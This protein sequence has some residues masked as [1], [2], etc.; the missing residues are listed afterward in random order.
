MPDAVPV[1]KEI[2]LSSADDKTTHAHG[3]RLASLATKID[4]FAFS[5]QRLLRRALI[6]FHHNNGVTATQASRMTRDQFEKA[7]KEY[8]ERQLTMK[9]VRSF[10]YLRASQPNVP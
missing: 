4:N 3:K 5:Q 1:I 6:K 8:R 2:N 9:A 10:L 7:S